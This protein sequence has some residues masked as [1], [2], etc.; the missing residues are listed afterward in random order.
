[1]D[2]NYSV[3]SYH[4]ARQ[5]ADR[6]ELNQAIA[7]LEQCIK[8]EV[9]YPDG[10]ILLANLYQD[11]SRLVK[12]EQA[13]TLASNID[14][15]RAESIA[16]IARIHRLNG[17]TEE[18]YRFIHEKRTTLRPDVTITLSLSEICLELG[19]YH[20]VI[21]EIEDLLNSGIITSIDEKKNLLHTLGKLYDKD[22]RYDMAFQAHLEA[23]ELTVSQYN[24]QQFERRI[25]KIRSAYTKKFIGSAASSAIKN[26]QP[27]FIVGMPRSGST[28]LEQIL[29]CHT[30]IHAAGELPL[31]QQLVAHMCKGGYPEKMTEI[32]AATLRRCAQHYIDTACSKQHQ[33]TTD[34]MPHNYLYLGVIH[35]LFPKSK[36]IHISR[37]PVDNCL[38]IYFQFFNDSHRY[39]TRLSNIAHHYA[40][41]RRMMN[42]WKKQLPD[43]IIEL[44][45]ENLVKNTQHEVTRILGFLG[46]EW[47]NRCLQHDKNRRHVL[48]ASQQQVNKPIYE[49]SI[50]RWKNYKPYISSLLSELQMHNLA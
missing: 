17:K 30:D 13:Y 23:N 22:N 15:L 27:V 33:F 32:D 29:S 28:L 47:Q 31:I 4:S 21:T 36:I 46:L 35:Q 43:S 34:K 41:H 40:G 24:P 50:E 8:K 44:S 16:G 18:A 12:A 3:Q 38:S 49:E 45:Y 11:S 6:G 2:N 25:E 39:A 19:K 37:Q 9:M 42:T 26:H 10:Y 7:V 5:L 14:R 20:E 1:M 48:T